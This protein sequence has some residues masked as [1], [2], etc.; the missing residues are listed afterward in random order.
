[1]GAREGLLKTLLGPF[2]WTLSWLLPN[3][4]E[5]DKNGSKSSPEIAASSSPNDPST[6]VVQDVAASAIK[7]DTAS[8]AVI[9][10]N[11]VS[12]SPAE[13]AVST[14]ADNVN[15]P[16][17]DPSMMTEGFSW[18][19][20]LTVSD[21]TLVL[22]VMFSSVFFANFYFGPRIAGASTTAAG[23]APKATNAQRIGMTIAMLSIFPAL[24]MP[25]GLLLYFIANILTTNLQ[26]RWLAFTKPVHPA[27]GACKRP[28]RVQASR[29]MADSF[30]KRARAKR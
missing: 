28:I 30:E 8:S 3:Q 13:A 29:E 16:W 10:P 6:S 27:P 4:A 1:M 24:K 25:A 12:A 14:V 9:D 26:M 5:P 17:F 7:Q 21:P 23:Q 15:S 19:Q 20:D 22:P 2:D 11:A 18:C